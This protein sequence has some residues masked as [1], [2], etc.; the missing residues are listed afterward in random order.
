MVMTSILSL[1]ENPF[2]VNPEL[3]INLRNLFWKTRWTNSWTSRPQPCYSWS[4]AFLVFF[5]HHTVKNEELAWALWCSQNLSEH[6]KVSQNAAYNGIFTL[7]CTMKHRN[8]YS[9]FLKR[10]DY[11]LKFSTAPY[12]YNNFLS[13]MFSWTSG[14]SNLLF[15]F[16]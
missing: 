4:F 10:Q 15:T 2:P 9:W 8:T 16:T 1:Y 6:W 13:T 7:H 11:S 3:F 14:N 12:L 5:I